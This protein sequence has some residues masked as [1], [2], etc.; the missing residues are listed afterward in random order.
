MKIAGARVVVVLIGLGLAPLGA[1]DEPQPPTTSDWRTLDPKG[2][3]FSVLMPG[4]PTS[5]TSS[6]TV[7][8]QSMTTFLWRSTPRTGQGFVVSYSDYPA[9]TID[10]SI[11]AVYHYAIQ[12]AVESTHGQV[13]A[14]RD[15]R[16]G[17]Y[18][19]R[20]AELSIRDSTSGGKIKVIARY[21]LVAPRLYGM[22]TTSSSGGSAD[23]KRFFE[24][25]V[26]KEGPR[27]ASVVRK[28]V[29]PSKRSFSS[30]E[31]SFGADFP[32]TPRMERSPG[33][34]ANF[35]VRDGTTLYSVMCKEYPEQ[36]EPKHMTMRPG[37][38]AKG[39]AA[40]RRDVLLGRLIG[41]ETGFEP[42]SP[43]APNRGAFIK[44]R[45][46]LTERRS[47]LVRYVEDHKGDSKGKGDA[48]LDSFILP[49]EEVL[50]AEQRKSGR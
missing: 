9:G 30:A 22:S 20:E 47:Y 31:W 41:R 39:T 6:K 1:A 29:D 42:G 45:S 36:E 15:V 11:D 25:F 35:T 4:K 16:V 23:T 44:F 13:E 7:D 34:S 46:Y 48:F 26:V 40:E 32:R 17:G 5:T 3:G 2:G 33:N 21:V 43:P 50:G 19:G 38:T 12:G 27:L 37:M 8:G 10:Q 24:S 14:E 28:P 18:P 49:L